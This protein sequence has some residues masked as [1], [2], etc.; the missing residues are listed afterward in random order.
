MRRLV[1][2][3]I[4]IP[5]VI[6][7]AFVVL[8]LALISRWQGAPAEVGGSATEAGS[9]EQTTAPWEEG[10]PSASLD[11][12][13][14]PTTSDAKEY[15]M[16]FGRAIWTYDTTVHSFIDWQDAVGAFADPM[17]QAARVAQSMLPYLSQW[18]QLEI[19]KAK[20]TVTDVIAD[21][22]PE[23]RALENNPKAPAGWHGYLIRG[24]QTSIVDGEPMVA[25]R[26]V[27]VGL[28]C[29]P[30]CKFWSATTETPT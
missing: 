9:S 11:A 13:Q 2:T 1:R 30:Q 22:T 6:L 23:L 21:S 24:K 19:H 14:R 17:S 15:A 8:I 20:A 28:V 5:I 3:H 25:D 4:M 16:A 29:M 18:E 10:G 26:Q 7:L 12:W 27:T